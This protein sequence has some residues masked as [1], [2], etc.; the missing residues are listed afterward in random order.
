MSAV[1][2]KPELATHS[3]VSRMEFPRAAA[4]LKDVL[5]ARLVAY[6]GDVSETRAVREWADGVRKPSEGVQ[7]RL[8]LALTVALMIAE[9]DDKHVAQAWFQGLNPQLDDISPAR[10][11]R[12][13]DYD[14]AGKRVLA[15]A[16]AFMVR[17]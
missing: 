14:D 2:S 5:G 15:A 16:R 3:E 4:K 1:R 17:G 6:L 7:Q 8:R 13:G 10:L 9:R 12:D 11:L